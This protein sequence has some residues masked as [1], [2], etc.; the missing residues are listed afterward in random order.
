MAG[1][2]FQMPT[3]LSVCSSEE[4]ETREEACTSVIRRNSNVFQHPVSRN[5]QIKRG[6]PNVSN[7]SIQRVE[8]LKTYR[9]KFKAG[10]LEA[11]LIIFGCS[12]LRGAWRDRD[13][14]GIF[15]HCS[16]NFYF[17]DFKF[18]SFVCPS[19]LHPFLWFFLKNSF[20]KKKNI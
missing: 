20:R 10:P 18:S 13:M 1:K 8:I 9:E 7:D 6:C 16:L 15:A 14:N 17:L 5:T 12:S 4:L 19:E 3:A 11:I 2:R